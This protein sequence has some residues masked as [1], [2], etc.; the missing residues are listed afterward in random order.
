VTTSARQLA[1]SAVLALD[2]KRIEQLDE[3]LDRQQGDA[4]DLA[5]ARELALGAV[6]FARLYDWLTHGFLRPGPQPPALLAAL[7]VGCHQLFACDRIPPHA[8][9]GETVE[10]LR[11][12]GNPHL[13]GVANAVL[14]KCAALRLA[15][16]GGE[17]PLG[18]LDER[19][20]PA[21]PAV[22]HSLPDLLVDH[23][24]PLLVPGERTLAALDQMAP[25][26]TRS[27]PGLPPLQ[28]RGIV[29]REGPWCWW[30]DPAEA[31]SGPVA[32]GRCVVQD[33][34]QGEVVE[35][36]RPRPGELVL[37]LCAAPGGKSRAFLDAGCRVVSA[38][39]QA[40]K[41]R[42]LA[43][44]RFITVRCDGRRP[45]F[46][47]ASFDAVVVDAP[48]SNSGVLARRPEARWRYTAA[49]LA[50]LAGLQRSLL[51]AAAPLVRPDGRLVYATCSLS[52]GENQ[53]VAHALPGWRLLAERLTWP[54]PWNA[55]GYVAVLVRG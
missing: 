44:D 23:L 1:L 19:H 31:L 11:A 6:R 54:G 3:M 15:E 55:G 5:L 26:C 9:V 41:C 47:P 29:R 25:L 51:E 45:A 38:E 42:A 35:A 8:A 32:D 40:A 24:A 48:C 2:Q 36:A 13:S 12:S 27:R 46:A 18:R 53:A 17:G 16:R 33:P 50:S 10:A 49:A 20:Q 4:R 21:A 37:D 28:G 34:S 14:R 30:Q 39:L 22:R 43:A 7:R 52:P